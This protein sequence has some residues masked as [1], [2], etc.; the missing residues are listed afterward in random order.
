MGQIAINQGR[1]VTPDGIIE[2]GTVIT[3]NE[4]ILAVG[5]SEAVKIPQD[6]QIIDAG[7]RWIAPGL[8]D[9]QTHGGSGFDY[10]TASE[11]EIVS[12]LRWEASRGV[13]GVLPTVATASLEDL[14]GMISRLKQVARQ[15][16]EGAAR[17]LGI[18]QEGPYVNPSKRG[19]QPAEH[20]RNPD[21]R[22]MAQIL[23]AADGLIRIVTLAPE[24]PGGLEFVRYL[25]AQGVMPSI[26]HSEA[27]YDEVM[28]A[29]DAGLKRATHLYNG[30]SRFDHRDPGA[31]GAVLVSDAIYAEL[32]LDGKHI[33]PAA[34]KLALRAKG[35]GRIV[36]V[37][38]STQ[39]AGL[40]DGVYIRPG[41]RKIIVKDGEARLESGSL[42][43]SVL[44][45]DR[46][47]ANAVGFMDISLPQAL[48]LAS[49]TAA[50]STGLQDQT[51]S[52]EP[53]KGADIIIVDD[54]MTVEATLVMG[55]VVYRRSEIKEK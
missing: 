18:H 10:M 24:L 17:I 5:S 54:N 1:V 14:L 41:N 29:A 16:P 7:G 11:E 44:T 25:S 45:L 49:R 4:R 40:P 9:G 13:T 33:H 47:V 39:A 2:N 42:A 8:I 35:A 20:I 53:G 31:V 30:M 6:A 48:D 50:E 51:G 22:E 38:D 21:I 26:G 32:I 23:E 55:Q 34:A 19:A 15:K 46:A 28:A 27:T 43:G 37:T 52:L 12:V 3:E 36:L